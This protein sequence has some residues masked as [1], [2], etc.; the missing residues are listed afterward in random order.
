MHR[1]F[2]KFYRKELDTGMF[3][4][5]KLLAF[6]L[7][8][9][10]KAAHK[11]YTAMVRFQK[12]QLEAGQFIFGRKKAA[13]ELNMSEGIIRNC[14]K[15]LKESG[16]VT[17]RS[18]NKFSI[19]TIVNWESEQ[20]GGQEVTSKRP[21][22]DQQAVGKTAVE[23][24]SKATSEPSTLTVGSE[25]IE[26]SDN[27]ETT[28][29]TTDKMTDKRPANSRQSDHIQEEK[30]IKN[31]KKKDTREAGID[32][33]FEIFFEAYPKRVGR[34]QALRAWNKLRLSDEQVSDILQA[35]DKQK[36][37]RMNAKPGEFRPEWPDP[38]TWLNNNR[39]ED[40]ITAVQRSSKPLQPVQP[41]PR[42]KLCPS[43]RCDTMNEEDSEFCKD[44][45]TKMSDR[46]DGAVTDESPA[47]INELIERAMPGHVE[48]I[49]PRC[50]ETKQ[51]ASLPLCLECWNKL[52][53]RVRMEIRAVPTLTKLLLQECAKGIPLE[54]IEIK[55][56]MAKI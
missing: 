8:C 19:L 17:V 41:P 54:E 15:I 34:K 1:G 23:T 21:A 46:E 36:T 25:A 29:K 12:I 44:C 43:P 31:E 13:Y 26:R 20:S 51:K 32:S 6:W 14:L 45:H 50:G 52:K 37:W 55:E 22:N 33:G 18:T 27:G 10:L 30:N 16:E 53:S 3:K 4:N 49:C 48:A 38:A 9:H 5:H 47:P 11:N 35:I 7:W 42:L 39:W 2:I 56:E 28:S 40:E 24:T